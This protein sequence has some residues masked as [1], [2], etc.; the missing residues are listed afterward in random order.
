LDAL[1]ALLAGFCARFEAATLPEGFFAD[2][3]ASD[4]LAYRRI[5]DDNLWRV[6]RRTTNILTKKS[7]LD[8]TRTHRARKLKA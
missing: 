3:H 7:V 8:T 6:T 5:T 2:I 4:V 1:P